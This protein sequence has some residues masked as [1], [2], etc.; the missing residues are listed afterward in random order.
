MAELAI[1]PRGR[2]V[3]E[4]PSPSPPSSVVSDQYF[5]SRHAKSAMTLLCFLYVQTANGG[6]Q[7]VQRLSC[8][9]RDRILQGFDRAAAPVGP[10]RRGPARSRGALCARRGARDRAGVF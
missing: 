1:T 3:R 6:M 5:A 9:E 2:S 8:V 7:F 4:R 10:R